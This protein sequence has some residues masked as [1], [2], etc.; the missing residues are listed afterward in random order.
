MRHG[1]RARGNLHM[2]DLDSHFVIIA[3][4]LGLKPAMSVPLVLQ[5]TWGLESVSQLCRFRVRETKP[6]SFSP[7]VK[8]GVD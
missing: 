8:Y 5:Q 7:I 3:V 2:A 4:C 6:F 1:L